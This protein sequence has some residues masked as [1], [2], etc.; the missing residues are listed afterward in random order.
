MS[1][2]DFSGNVAIVTGAGAGL[3]ENYAIELAKRGVRV[4]VN[5]LGGARDGIGTSHAPANQVV[6]KIKSIGGEAIPSFDDVTTT[7]GGENI[8]N[9]ALDAFGKVDILINNAGILRDKS[10]AKLEPEDWDSVLAV[11][12]RA[13]YCVTRPAFLHM[14]AREYGRIVFTSSGAGTY[15]NFGQSNYAAAKMGVVG[16]ANVLKIEG[17][18]YNIAAN[19]IVPSA[20]TRMTENIV[21]KD[22]ADKLKPSYV[23]P[24]VLYMSSRQC[25]DSGCVINAFGGYYSRSAIA[26]GTGVVF[27]EIP[28]PEQIEER[29]D[30]IMNID[31]AEYYDDV[32]QMMSQVLQIGIGIQ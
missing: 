1:N 29:W 24:A 14:K 20:L 5:D 15:G 16:L 12:L 6:E 4:V 22:D 18:R 28:S 17:A 30:R 8:V 2:I 19:V 27:D 9:T 7:E 13:A 31:E 25:R 23:V 11:H 3:G 10:F 32:S 21:D 26:T